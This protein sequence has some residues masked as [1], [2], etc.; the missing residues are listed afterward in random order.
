ME[1]TTEQRFKERISKLEGECEGL[2]VGNVRLDKGVFKEA[3]E[4]ANKI[5]RQRAVDQ[6]AKLLL[7]LD[8][9]RSAGLAK[10]AE[11]QK[12]DKELE[13]DVKKIN[14]ILQE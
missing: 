4:Q 13:K 12:L 6:A 5:K 14:S 7:D 1:D 10:I 3:V 8:D 9:K 2:R 11:L